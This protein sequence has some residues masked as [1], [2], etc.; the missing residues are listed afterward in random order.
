MDVGPA[1]VKLEDRV[2]RVLGSGANSDV[3]EVLKL[4]CWVFPA[5]G[6]SECCAGD[7]GVAVFAPMGI[8]SSMWPRP[9]L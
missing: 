3:Q 1:G 9:H 4:G 6:G 2:H 5:D 8:R 7:R